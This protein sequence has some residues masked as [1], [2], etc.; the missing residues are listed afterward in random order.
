[1]GRYCRL[2]SHSE[3]SVARLA[4][5]VVLASS[6]S[7]YKSPHQPRNLVCVNAIHS[8]HKPGCSRRDRSS[9][10]QGRC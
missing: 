2:A 8:L 10:L 9:G 4:Q 5:S 6:P 3:G 7:G 1:M